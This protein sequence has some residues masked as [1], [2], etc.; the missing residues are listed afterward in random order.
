MNTTFSIRVNEKVKKA[1]LSKTRAKWLEWGML[2]RQFM[3][4][5]NKNPDIIKFEIDDAIFDDMFNNKK[6]KAKLEKISDKMD[7]LWL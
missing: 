2:L 7:T 3:E 1:F 6:V 4:Y 5:Y